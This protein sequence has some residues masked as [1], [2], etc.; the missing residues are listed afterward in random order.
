MVGAPASRDAL[1]S[2]GEASGSDVDEAVIAAGARTFIS[3]IL[4]E[5]ESVASV[6]VGHVNTSVSDDDDASS[7]R[8]EVY[9]CTSYSSNYASIDDRSDEDAVNIGDGGDDDV[10]IGQCTPDRE[11]AKARAGEA[12]LAGRGSFRRRFFGA[13][14]GSLADGD[15]ELDV[16]ESAASIVDAMDESWGVSPPRRGRREPPPPLSRSPSENDVSLLE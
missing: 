1:A 15:D 7:A 14:R 4:S 12:A 13:V 11:K 10:V 2:S 3:S 5:S 16:Y 6:P 9:P 8:A